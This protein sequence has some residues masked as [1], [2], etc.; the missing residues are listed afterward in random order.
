MKNTS[1]DGSSSAK[2]IEG[3]Y[4]E[5][6][7]SG[8]QK[9][10]SFW[11]QLTKKFG[12]IAEEFGDAIDARASGIDVN[13][14]VLKNKNIELANSVFSQFDRAKTKAFSTWFFD[15]YPELPAARVV[16]IGCDNGVLLSLL[17]KRYPN[18]EFIGIDPCDSAIEL[19][20]HRAL[21]L[22]LSN[23]KFYCADLSNLGPDLTKKPFD[24]VVAVTVFH[25]IFANGLI[26][27][28]SGLMATA[29]PSASISSGTHDF[30]IQEKDQE[31][32]ENIKKLIG[33]NGSLISADRWSD[34]Y[35]LL[36]WIKICEQQGIFVN[37]A[38]S[39]LLEFS[40]PFKELE[41]LPVTVLRAGQGR[42]VSPLD[43]LSFF[44]YRQLLYGDI[45]PALKHPVLSELMY[46]A[47]NRQMIVKKN[48]DY[49]DGS[50]I[51][52]LE[53]GLS[54]GVVYRYRISTRGFREFQIFP[55]FF[56]LELISEVFVFEAARADVARMSTE[57]VDRDMLG[58]LGIDATTIEKV[59]ADI[60]R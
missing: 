50:G 22:G 18:S 39:H 11:R 55:S 4:R 34:Q 9:P 40:S 46:E 6:G 33:I 2:Y 3:V 53:Y 30:L 28:C 23:V 52:I 17:A 56:I 43:V 48:Y 58:S 19:A 49:L 60:S 5:L 35:Q 42:S 24:I 20:N 1:N 41:T 32:F 21:S 7:I 27:D 26:G 14:Y 54:G 47:L 16:E 59:A 8:S 44:G 10:E 36:R 38:E 45:N 31:K 51:E 57:Y 25:E 12:K 29:V 13:P 37:L 15:A